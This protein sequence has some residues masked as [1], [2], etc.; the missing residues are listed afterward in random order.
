[1]QK[2]SNMGGWVKGQELETR[3]GSTERGK[4]HRA[5]TLMSSVLK[6]Q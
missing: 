5:V 6:Q 3:A 2:G 4:N 1:M